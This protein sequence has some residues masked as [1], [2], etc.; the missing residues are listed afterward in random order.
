MEHRLGNDRSTELETAVA[1]LV[2]IARDRL[3]PSRR[4]GRHLVTLMFL[5]GTAMSGQKDHACHAGLDL[6]R[7]GPDHGRATGSSP[8]A[9]SSPG[10]CRSRRA[11]R[12]IDGELYEMPEAVLHDQLL[13]AEPA[14]AGARDDPADRRRGGPCHVPAAERLS[15]GDKVVDIS[16]LGGFRAYQRFLAANQ[17]LGA[18]CW[19]GPSGERRQVDAG[20]LLARLAARWP[21]SSA[22][23]PAGGH[24]AGLVGRVADGRRPAARVG[25]RRRA[26]TRGSTRSAT[27]SRSGPAPQPGA[28]APRHRQPP[29]H[30]PGRRRP[31][32][33]VRRGR[34]RGRS[35]PPC[36]TRG[37][38]LR[39]PVRAVAFANEEGVR[40]PSLHGQ[41][42]RRRPGRAGRAG[43]APGRT[44]AP[45]ARSLREAGCRPDGLAAGGVAAGAAA[46]VEL[47]IEQG[48][49]LDAS[50]V[51]VGVVTAITG[52]QRGTIEVTGRAN[53]AGTT[54]MDHAPRRPGRGRRA[55]AGGR[56]PGRPGPLRRGDGRPAAGRA[57]RGQRDPGPGGDEPR[58]PIPSPTTADE[59]AA[60]GTG[61]PGQGD[62]QRA[63]AYEVELD[64]LA[65][66]RPVPADPAV[67]D[68]IEAAARALGL[69][70]LRLPSGAG[71][72]CAIL[73]GLGTGRDDLRAKHGGRQPPLVR[74]HGRRR[75]G[76]RGPGAAPLLDRPRCRGE[77]T[78]RPT[79]ATWPATESTRP[80]RVAGPG[81]A[82]RQLRD[83]LGGRRREQ[84]PARRRRFGGRLQDVIGAEPWPG[85]RHPN[86]ESMFEYGSR[87][88]VWR[89]LRLFTAAA[90]RSPCSRWAWRW[91]V[92][93]QVVR[94][95]ADMGH[96]ICSHGYRWIDYR[97]VDPRR[98]SGSTSGLAVASHRGRRRG[99]GRSAGTPAAAGRTP[100]GWSWRPAA[101]CTTRDSYADDLPY[102]TTEVGAAAPGRSPTPSTSTTCASSARPASARATTSSRT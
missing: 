95:M 82:G 37:A 102:W 29:R 38:R 79:P 28:A 19:A 18:R 89:L 41:P 96:E 87:A 64:L 94:R 60:R 59:V 86:V 76:G 20:R 39:H 90:S 77:M 1:A 47:H 66:T 100:V 44:A 14:G 49:V 32:R 88:G 78:R 22:L 6:P 57:G 63:A 53:H 12:S 25:R 40:R 31:G 27:S 55:R 10:C 15:A 2:S 11:G 52:Q 3:R 30:R 98:S 23:A 83:Q 24:P 17:R 92:S 62:R 35:W 42:G 69:E 72:D 54:P 13:P 93:P 85:L 91:N 80:I 45:S 58:R 33:G 68:I 34:R 84:H 97:D 99:S 50:G 43:A 9:T 21:G 73:A 75:A 8:S 36:R 51:P 4:G 101:S 61:A 26:P 48:P 70:S 5:N 65:P 46:F 56:E 81:P 74:G 67:E 16:E 71:H 7:T